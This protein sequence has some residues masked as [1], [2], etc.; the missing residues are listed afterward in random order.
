MDAAEALGG[1]RQYVEE[2]AFG[3]GEDIGIPQPHD[4][5]AIIGKIPGP[6][7]VGGNPVVML[8]AVER[9]AELC[10]TAGQINDERCHDQL[11][12]EGRT[13]SRDTL[14][15]DAFCRRRI[16]AQLASASCQFRIDAV[17]NE[18]SVDWRTA[19]ANPPPAPPCQGGEK[20]VYRFTRVTCP[21]FRPGRASCLP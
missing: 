7:F 4:P 20:F 10:G 5:P 9:Y 1:C 3:I 15:Y 11:S 14:P 18:V 13:V 12:G 2:R 17:P 19:H 8:A 21:I 16:I 6:P